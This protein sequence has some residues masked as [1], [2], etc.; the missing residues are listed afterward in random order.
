MI[1]CAKKECEWHD[2]CKV[3]Q[4]VTSIDEHAVTVT[5]T[6]QLRDVRF[7]CAAYTSEPAS[8]PPLKKCAHCGGEIEIEHCPERGYLWRCKSCNDMDGIWHDTRL[9]AIKAANRRPPLPEGLTEENIKDMAECRHR[10]HAPSYCHPDGRRCSCF[11][12]CDE[13]LDLALQ[14]L[15]ERI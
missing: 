11:G 6:V 10:N 15:H 13:L 3:I 4:H 12:H 1:Q 5:A 9:E 7:I 14:T 8:D 2:E